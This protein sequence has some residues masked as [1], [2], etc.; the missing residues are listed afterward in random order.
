MRFEEGAVD[1]SKIEVGTDITRINAR[2]RLLFDLYYAFEVQNTNTQPRTTTKDEFNVNLLGEYDIPHRFFL[3]G[4]PAVEWDR[5]RNIGLRNYPTAGLGYR[6]FTWER[7]ELNLRGGLGY[8]W[9][10]F[11]GTDA[12][13]RNFAAGHLGLE[14]TILFP[15]DIE[16][17]L[18]TAY[19]PGLEDPDD[20]WLFRM[21][22][23]LRVPIYGP[24]SLNITVREVNDGNPTPDVGNNKITTSW[25]FGLRF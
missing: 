9:E 24:L 6:L 17:G 21:R 19:L 14:S 2:T 3:W 4:L 25:A 8:I 11:T 7:F 18:R 16:L 12:E 5:P 10:D 1:K 20:E 23:R 13:D 22:A 15:L